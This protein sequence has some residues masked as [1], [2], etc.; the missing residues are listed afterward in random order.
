MNYAPGA[1]VR[2]SVPLVL[3][4]LLGA[5]AFTGAASADVRVSSGSP[6]GPFSQNK[7]NEPALAVDA[8]DT[9]VLAAGSNDEIDTEAC[10]ADPPDDCPFTPGVGVSGIY[11]SFDGGQTWTQPTYPGYSARTC[12]GPQECTPLTPEQGG[13]IG[14]LPN[15]YE[16]G[17]ASDG[18]P[19]LAF[20]PRP[21][22]AGHFSWA[23]GSRLYYAN[24]TSNLSDK[25]SAV[26]KGFEAL[27]VSHTDDARTAAAGGPAGQRAW[28]NPVIATKQSSTTFSDEEQIW[29]DNASSSPFFGNV[30]ICHASYRSNTPIRRT[31]E[32]RSRGRSRSRS[33][34][35]TTPTTW[36]PALSPNRNA[37]Y[38]AYNAFTTDYQPTTATPRAL[39]GGL[40]SAPIQGGD[41]GTWTSLSHGA[42]GDP[43]GS[44][45]NN[46]VAEFLGDYVYAVG[47][48]NGGAGVWNDV[49]NAAD[50]PA[51][52][53]YRQSYENAVR[54][55]AIP[56]NAQEDSPAEDDTDA[57]AAPPKKG[58]GG[59]VPPEPPEVGSECPATFGN[60]D[61]YRAS[62]IVTP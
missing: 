36:R 11:F 18:D 62:T 5:L 30:Y 10:A 58:G 37:V 17:L 27:A 7:Q 29:A 60:S 12:L 19:A 44:S 24:L 4:A 9:R 46:L 51:V 45:Q 59:G 53:A 1:T 54:S 21:D 25:Q 55:G 35:V 2:R 38:L 16:N 26:F 57:D 41:A 28:S 20:G 32:S 15:Y 48:R 39:V 6:P 31:R 61:I 42:A 49:R 23:N 56:P 50:C 8:H 3:T 52:D 43:R 34:R 22:A 13:Q 14:T 40:L 33:R 47:T